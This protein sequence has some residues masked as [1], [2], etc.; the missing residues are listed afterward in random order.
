LALGWKTNV[1]EVLRLEAKQR[2]CGP[3]CRR[4]SNPCNLTPSSPC[5]ASVG[6]CSRA[7]DVELS[8]P[9]PRL[10]GPELNQRPQK[11][12]RKKSLSGP[13]SC[14]NFDD[15]HVDK[16]GRGGTLDRKPRNSNTGKI[17]QT[18]PN[19]PYTFAPP[20]AVTPGGCSDA[21]VVARHR[22]I[23]KKVKPKGCRYLAKISSWRERVR[24][25]SP[26]PNRRQQK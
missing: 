4:T 7:A 5:D 19:V 24:F 22:Y 14:S 13:T 1:G 12:A 6:T 16:P 25:V 21:K 2:G 23:R 17:L 10:L 18:R 9:V 3:P 8:G 26:H 11:L 15:P 20:S